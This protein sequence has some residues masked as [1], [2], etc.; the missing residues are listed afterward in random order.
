M[1]KRELTCIGCPMGCVITVEIEDDIIKNIDGYSCKAG[2]SYAKSEITNPTRIVTTTVKVKN[3][4]HE[5][6]SVKTKEAVP[7]EKIWD[8]LKSLK[9]VCVNAPVC[10]GDV[11]LENVA[12]TG[13]PV[14]ATKSISI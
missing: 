12:D 3:K 14:V 1:I 9:N 2:V 13:I 6:L 10:I 4:S 11:I 7:R 5:M 8:C